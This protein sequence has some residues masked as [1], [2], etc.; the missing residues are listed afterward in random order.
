[1]QAGFDCEECLSPALL[2][3]VFLVG[4]I[5]GIGLLVYL[6]NSEIEEAKNGGVSLDTVFFKIVASS[7]QI[8]ATALAFAFDWDDGMENLI[9][10]Q[11][12]VC[13]C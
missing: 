9:G 4:L 12:E 10:S 11:A 13:V 6:V 7:F 1:M 3:I 5:L 8:N 2:A